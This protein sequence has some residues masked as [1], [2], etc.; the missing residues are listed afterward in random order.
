[1]EQFTILI[2][3]CG[4]QVG[5]CVCVLGPGVL[6]VDA[7]RGGDS[8]RSSMGIPVL[9]FFDAELPLH[10][11]CDL[12]LRHGAALATQEPDSPGRVC[13][14]CPRS[15]ALVLM[16]NSDRLPVMRLMFSCGA[17]ILDARAPC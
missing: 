6:S 9:I 13:R 10:Y 15:A 17:V 8:W 3:I 14:T 11:F 16:A 5:V 4:Q 1:V 2:K 7:V 12:S